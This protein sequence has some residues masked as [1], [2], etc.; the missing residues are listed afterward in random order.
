MGTKIAFVNIILLIISFNGI[1]QEKEIS[2]KGDFIGQFP[3]S[4]VS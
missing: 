2:K 3:A 4:E 1:T